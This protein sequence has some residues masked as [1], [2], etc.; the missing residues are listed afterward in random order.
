MK[1]SIIAA[2]SENSVIG[3][4]GKIP[5]HIPE[6]LKRFKKITSGHH[7]IMGRKTFE[8]IGHPLP[9]RTNI[10][11]TRNKQSLLLRN[12]NYEA[13]G[14]KVVNSLQE[15]LSASK[16]SKEREVFI[17]G[18]EQIYKL[19][20]PIADEIYLTQVHHIFKGDAFFPKIDTGKW[21]EVSHQYHPKNEKNL[22]SYDF[23][24]FKKT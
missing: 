5:W 22:Y 4:K 7:V 2:V 1:I 19:A 10:I 8:A 23:V 20:L 13:P 14:C 16:I 9:N 15:A 17:I 3:Q 21:K 11:I 18:G 12:K 24:I 6:D